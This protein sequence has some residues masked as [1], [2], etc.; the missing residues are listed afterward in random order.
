[1]KR[2]TLTTRDGGKVHGYEPNVILAYKVATSTAQQ[3]DG[4][5]IITVDDMETN[6]TIFYTEA[7][8][9]ATARV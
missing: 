2:W 4:G 6:N 9:Q 7:V 1:M 5:G 3:C 8:A